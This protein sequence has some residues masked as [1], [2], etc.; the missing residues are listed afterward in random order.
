MDTTELLNDVKKMWIEIADARLSLQKS[1]VISAL[2]ECMDG[3]NEELIKILERK[4]D[5]VKA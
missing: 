3:T 2:W 4:I 5:E 1:K